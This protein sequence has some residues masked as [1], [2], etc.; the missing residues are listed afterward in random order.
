MNNAHIKKCYLNNYVYRLRI[1][2]M[3]PSSISEQ[4]ILKIFMGVYAPQPPSRAFDKFLAWT[5]LAQIKL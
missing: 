1:H 4:L 3:L 2:K 5:K